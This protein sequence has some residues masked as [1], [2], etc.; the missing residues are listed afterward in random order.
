MDSTLTCLPTPWSRQILA[1]PLSSV[2]CGLIL[3]R[4][5][6]HVDVAFNEEHQKYV[7]RRSPSSGLYPTMLHVVWTRKYL[8]PTCR[9]AGAVN[10]NN[11]ATWDGNVANV[12]RCEATDAGLGGPLAT[13]MLAPSSASLSSPVPK[14]A[15]AAATG[16]GAGAGAGASAAVARHVAVE[17]EVQPGDPSAVYAPDA[18][19]TS[20]KVQVDPWTPPSTSLGRLIGR[21]ARPVVRLWEQWPMG[22]LLI[23]LGSLAT[24]LLVTTGF[25]YVYTSTADVDV[26]AIRS[27]YAHGMERVV[28]V[29]NTLVRSGC[30]D[31]ATEIPAA[32]ATEHSRLQA[33]FDGSALPAAIAATVTAFG[34]CVVV[35]TCVLW[36]GVPNVPGTHTASGDHEAFADALLGRTTAAVPDK[37]EAKAL[38]RRLLGYLTALVAVVCTAAAVVWTLSS[39]FSFTEQLSLDTE[40]WA[41]DWITAAA[42]HPA[43]A[44]AVQ[45]LADRYRESPSMLTWRAFGAGPGDARCDIDGLH[46]FDGELQDTPFLLCGAVV[47]PNA[48]TYIPALLIPAAMLLGLLIVVP[49]LRGALE[50]FVEPVHLRA[51]R[52]PSRAKKDQ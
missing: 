27:A 20:G 41:Q 52:M 51:A 17:S 35:L 23:A 24:V 40:A 25:A 21:L 34:M 26:D 18:E 7:L 32:V 8:N 36:V 14:H 37:P 16:T 12:D 46:G 19:A 2:R 50:E 11:P 15:A 43:C 42:A 33:Q 39:L 28:D 13:A 9:L 31:A 22:W 5:P 47:L 45:P 49:T 30:Q 44:A 38:Q 48:Q 1:D 29:V 6:R 4:R 3:P 10:V